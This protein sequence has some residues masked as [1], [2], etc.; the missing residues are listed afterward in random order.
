VSDTRDRFDEQANAV[1][2]S[3]LDIIRPRPDITAPDSFAGLTRTIAAALRST[4][5]EAERRGELK[6]LEMACHALN[7]T[8]YR[9][10]LG[11]EHAL[12]LLEARIAELKKGAP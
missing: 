5:E 1:A 10:A 11:G 8:P 6:G 7:D 2:I 4:S 3:L 9:I 12:Q